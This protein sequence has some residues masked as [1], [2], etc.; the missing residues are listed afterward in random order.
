MTHWIVELF[1]KDS[2]HFKG[3]DHAEVTDAA[4]KIQFKDLFD[5]PESFCWINVSSLELED[6]VHYWA[7][8]DDDRADSLKDA[9]HMALYDLYQYTDEIKEGDTFEC[10][11]QSVVYRFE[12]KDVHVVPTN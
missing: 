4:G 8:V 3:I 7:G 5:K 11:W 12:C 2:P 10:E 6:G 9:L 1:P